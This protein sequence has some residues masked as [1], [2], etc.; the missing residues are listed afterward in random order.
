MKKVQKLSFTAMAA[1]IGTTTLFG[2]VS[3]LAANPVEKEV[4]VS[5]NNTQL[6]PDP[7]NPTDPKWGVS[8][9]TAIS[10]KDNAT[11]VQ[12]PVQL[13]SINQ[14]TPSK[15]VSQLNGLTVDISIE[16]LNA[17]KLQETLNNNGEE[18]SYTVAYDT[19]INTNGVIARLSQNNPVQPG[20][21]S[22]DKQSLSVGY[23]TDTLT[24]TIEETSPITKP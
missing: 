20:T 17:Y 23:F 11:A 7:G 14:G 5:Y 6:I 4:P 3:A 21:A 13:Y 15:D 24:Y 1:I 19:Q 8:I 10:F 22:L 2:N 9:P 18:L 12:I 16:S